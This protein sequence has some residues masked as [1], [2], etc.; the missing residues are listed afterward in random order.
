MMV[1]M[2]NVKMN[3]LKKALVRGIVVLIPT[4]AVAYLTDKMVYVVPMLAAMGFVA[5]SLFEDDTTKRIEDDGQYKDFKDQD[6]DS[7]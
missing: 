3:G 2:R 7:E 4:Y 5:A 6:G 1:C